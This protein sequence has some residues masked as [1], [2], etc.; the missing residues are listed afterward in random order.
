MLAVTLSQTECDIAELIGRRRRQISI[1]YDRILTKRDFTSDG[2]RNDIE[3]SAAEL[4]VAKYLNIYPEWSPTAGEVPKFDLRWRG[5]HLDV[6]NTDRLDGNLLIPYL[7]KTLIYFLVCGQMPNKQIMGCLKGDLVPER[8]RWREDL[9][10]QP[11][12]FVPSD[13][14]NQLKERQDALRG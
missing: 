13:R 11:C 5:V 7:D 10:H 9:P 8:G 1:M 3:A 12:W 6:K 2:I 4:A 14:L